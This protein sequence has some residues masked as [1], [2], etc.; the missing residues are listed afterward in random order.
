MGLRERRN[1]REKMVMQCKLEGKERKIKNC[2]KLRE[3]G[4][5][6]L[7]KILL[8]QFPDQ[9]TVCCTIHQMPFFLLIKTNLAV[10]KK[11]IPTVIIQFLS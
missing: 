6:V 11:N 1:V 8:T 2:K 9:G 4:L 7:P 3:N 10:I 5:C